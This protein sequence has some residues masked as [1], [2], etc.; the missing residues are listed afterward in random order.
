MSWFGIYALF[1]H[2]VL[3]GLII[4]AAVWLMTLWDKREDR[5]RP[6]AAE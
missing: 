6:T 5:R 4:V 1:I 3:A 2:P